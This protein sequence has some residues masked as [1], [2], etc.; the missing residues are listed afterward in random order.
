[1]QALGYAVLHVLDVPGHTAGH[2]AYFCA[3]AEGGPRCCFAATPCSRAVAVACLKAPP[4]K[5][6]A[7]LDQLAALPDDTRV[8]CAHEYTLANLKFARAVEPGNGELLHYS[9]QCETLRAQ[10][11][12]TLPSRMALERAINP[13]LRTR[14][15]T[16]AAAAAGFAPSTDTRDA[17]A[18]LAAL[19]E[20]K[21]GFR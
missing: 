16:V 17:V 13:F 9:A 19:R 3:Q 15:P 8:C 18:V 21:N 11:L 10:G 1:V 6:Q 7:S 14:T 20:W 5:M 4:R 2:I 12:P